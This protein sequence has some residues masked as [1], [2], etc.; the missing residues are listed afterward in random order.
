M[1]RRRSQ[2]AP[3]SD[4][5]RQFTQ[6]IRKAFHLPDDSELNITFTCDEPSSGSL[7]TLSG[8]GAYDAA[9]H[10]AAVSAAR[11][12]SLSGSSSDAAGGGE[13]AQLG[14]PPGSAGL[15]PPRV[16]APRVSS[17]GASTSGGSA[18]SGSASPRSEAGDAA[19]GHHD[20]A[21]GHTSSG[22]A[23]PACPHDAPSRRDGM[24]FGRKLRS[25]LTD[26]LVN[27]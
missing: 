21:G 22:G 2:V 12:S 25:A 7:L 16:R 20:D 18:A 4:G 23:R 9:V 3:G 5:Y 19:G 1:R 27:R 15:C 14:S 26:M 17:S 24:S 6:A 13:R 8:P 11:R 10:C